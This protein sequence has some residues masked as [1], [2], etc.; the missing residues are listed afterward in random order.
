MLFSYKA[1]SKTGEM[2]E[3]T[4]EAQDRLTLARDLR[5]RGYAPLSIEE[6]RKSFIS[7][8]SG[9][10]G[11]FSKVSVS[12]QIILTR[13]LSGMLRAGLSLAR[14]LSVLKKQ[15]KN[16]TLNKILIS[17]SDDINAGETLSHG[18]VKFSDIFSKLFVSMTRSGEESGNLSGALSDIGT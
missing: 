14:A 8:I 16:S 13:N 9:I 15:T 10:M 4:L 6:E 2:V 11:M 3:G 12:E 7:R 18:L 5:G 17:L 1:K